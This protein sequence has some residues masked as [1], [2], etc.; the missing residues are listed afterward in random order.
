MAEERD[1]VAAAVYQRES[2]VQTPTVAAHDTR[3]RRR[4]DRIAILFALRS[5]TIE[6]ARCHDAT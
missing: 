1:A 4:G 3:P 6:E 2:R 5:T